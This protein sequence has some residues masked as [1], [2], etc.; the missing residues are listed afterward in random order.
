MPLIRFTLSHPGADEA[1]REALL[2]GGTRIIVD[3]M[4]KPA[5]FVMATC[6]PADINFGDDRAPAAYV[7]LRSIG[8]LDPDTNVI[9]SERICELLDKRA[10]IPPERTFL[11]FVDVPRDSWGWNGGTFGQKR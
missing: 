7:E 1:I 10:N 5:R 4:D 8:G 9:L 2:E 11:N 6:E 3:V